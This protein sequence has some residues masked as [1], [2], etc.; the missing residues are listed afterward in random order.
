LPS[1][2]V[3]T[4][5]VNRAEQILRKVEQLASP[6]AHRFRNGARRRRNE[7]RFA[8]SGPQVDVRSGIASLGQAAKN[9]LREGRLSQPPLQVH[10]KL[11]A[12][13]DGR[14]QAGE[15]PFAIAERGACHDA[16]V[17]ERVLLIT[18]FA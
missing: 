11:L 5:R 8:V 2:S 18:H 4:L 15:F 13:L 17:L 10:E 3:V 14:R 12:A 9:G 1:A 16:T 6:A 7:R